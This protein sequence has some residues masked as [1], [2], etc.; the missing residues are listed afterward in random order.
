MT[1][2]DRQIAVRRLFKRG[3]T[4]S[5]IAAD[6]EISARLARDTRLTLGLHIKNK[7]K[8]KIK[9]HCFKGLRKSN[10]PDAEIGELYRGMRY[11]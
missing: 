11:G 7:C 10:L 8:P 2:K 3:K 5:E 6:L 1:P 4:D 9:N